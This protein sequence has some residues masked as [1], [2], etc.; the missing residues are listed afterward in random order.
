MWLRGKTGLIQDRIHEIARAIARKRTTGPVSSMRP[1]CQSHNQHARRRVAKARHRSGPVLPIHVR[2]SFRLT[3]GGA[4]AAQARAKLT[5]L[6]PPRQD[7]KALGGFRCVSVGHGASLILAACNI[8]AVSLFLYKDRRYGGERAEAGL[9]LDERHID[10][11]EDRK[12]RRAPKYSGHHDRNGSGF[13]LSRSGLLTATLLAGVLLLFG[14]LW[15]ARKTTHFRDLTNPAITAVSAPST[16]GGAEPLTL[17]RLPSEQRN[18]SEFSSATLLPGL[19]MQ[20]LQLNVAL[21]GGS[22]LPLLAGPTLDQA[23]SMPA[24]AVDAAPFHLM[25]SPAGQLQGQPT[26]VIGTSSAMD[27]VNRTEADGGEATGTFQVLTKDGRPAGV[28]A[29]VDTELTS[30]SF[31]ITVRLRNDA[32]SSR[33]FSL[34]WSPHFAAPDSDLRQFVLVVPSTDINAGGVVQSVQGIELD[35]SAKSGKS[36]PL[37]SVKDLDVTFVNLQRQEVR[38]S[39]SVRLVDLKNNLVTRISLVSP[40]VRSVRVRTDASAH[41]LMLSFSTHD[42]DGSTTLQAG[43]SAEWHVRLDLIGRKPDD[44]ALAQ[45]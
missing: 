12:D 38:E 37:S 33:Q 34:T 27:V 23:A 2:P 17:T 6:D 36:L 31:D 9:A 43:E 7:G 35:F 44:A 24:S 5:R 30:R 14:L 25:L 16:I 15:L 40:S 26:D 45:P 41:T 32:L 22:I 18:T 4:V 1:R 42:L 29:K 39:P 13:S 3:Q 8:F 19:G 21:P 11:R 20:V 10:K 28:T